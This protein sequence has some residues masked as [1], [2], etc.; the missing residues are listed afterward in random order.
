MERELLTRVEQV[1]W[2]S[3]LKYVTTAALDR[4]IVQQLSESG[5]QREWYV[6]PMVDDAPGLDIRVYAEHGA[7]LMALTEVITQVPRWLRRYGIEATLGEIQVR[8]EQAVNDEI[9]QLIEGLRPR[10]HPR[11]SGEVR[12]MPRQVDQAC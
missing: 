8:S 12:I 10:N 11:E 5:Q 4:V 3:D 6:Y 1:V 2:V 9:Q 7:P